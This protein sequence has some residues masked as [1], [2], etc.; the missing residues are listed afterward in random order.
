MSGF[1]WVKPPS[2]ELIPNVERYAA[3][4]RVALD[5]VGQLLAQRLQ[6]YAQA[7][8]P[9]TDRT[10]NARQGLTGLSVA[11]RDMVTV[12]LFH[13]MDYGKWLEIAR[14]GPY[15][16]I[17]PTLQAHYGEVMRLLKSLLGGR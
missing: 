1:V 6:A 3:R 13:Q 9:W 15:R 5:A 14:G 2:A 7:N 8:A 16:I 12:Y 4:I 10:G 17:L 11:A